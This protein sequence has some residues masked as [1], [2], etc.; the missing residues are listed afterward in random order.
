MA[1]MILV[2]ETTGADLSALT[3]TERP[4]PPAPKPGE[5]AVEML[6][7]SINPA[8]VLQLQGLYGVKPKGVF[9]PGSEG[10]ARVTAV[11]DGVRGLSAGDIVVPMPMGCWAERLVLPAAA[12]IPLPAGVNLDQAAMLKVNPTTALVMLT[13][14]LPLAPGDWVVANAANSAVG[15]NLVTV[16]RALGIKVACVVR[17]EAAA[18]ALRDLGADAVIVDDGTGRP[19]RL[20]DGARAKLGLDAIGGIATERLG[21]CVADGGTIATY[22]LLS[23]ESPRLSANDLVFRGLTLQGFWLASWFTQTPPEKVRETYARLVGWLMEGRIGAPVTARYPFTDL[24]AAVDHAA[25]GHRDGKVL[26]LTRAHP[27]A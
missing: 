23:G 9:V 6:A 21:A 12:V 16:G 8:D 27:D 7:M 14:I 10:V 11:G 15:R 20:P 25:Q 17:R 26:M 24:A 13:D 22:G 4:A 1:D 5:V 19:P 3:L 18:T 2:A